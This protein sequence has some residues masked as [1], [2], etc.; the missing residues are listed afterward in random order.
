MI[1]KYVVKR[2]TSTHQQLQ[3]LFKDLDTDDDGA[4]SFVE[5]QQI[6]ESGCINTPTTSKDL[7]K[8][9]QKINKVDD[10]PEVSNRKSVHPQPNHL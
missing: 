9:Y 10:D 3:R 8:L 5:F 1:I 4:L 2:T 7:R 6:V